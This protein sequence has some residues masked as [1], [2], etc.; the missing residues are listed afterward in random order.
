MSKFIERIIQQ[1]LNAANLELEARVN[2][3]FVI[4]EIGIDLG[5]NDLVARLLIGDELMTGLPADE[6]E[7]NVVPVQGVDVNTHTLIK[8]LRKKFPEL[9]RYKV[10]P[11]E[12][13][14]LSSQGAAGVGYIHFTQLEDDQVPKRS[15]PGGTQG[16][17]RLFVSHGGYTGNVTGLAT[18]EIITIDTPIN[19]V[20][21]PDFP[22]GQRVPVGEIMELLGFAFSEGAGMG[23]NTNVTGLRIWKKNEAYLAREEAFVNDALFPYNVD[24]EDK[25]FYMF[26]EPVIFLPNEELKIE[27]QFKNTDAADE[28]GECFI[29]LF[30]HRR[31]TPVTF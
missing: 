5:A 3:G 30:F 26:P 15:D 11:G 6:G 10:A 27:G 2:E 9:P 19:P 23:A 18:A 31:F 13:L 28:S 4:N 17:S 22:F 16:P 24:D 20:G 1:D 7:E 21:L 8:T 29:T 12:K 25:P 14:V